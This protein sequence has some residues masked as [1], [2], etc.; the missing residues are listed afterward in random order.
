VSE[1]R[2][3]P[4]PPD[5]NLALTDEEKRA[6]VQLLRRTL[7]FDPYPYA[8]RRLDPLKSI[9]AKLVP[10]APQ[11]EPRAAIA[12]GHGTQPRAREAQTVKEG[13]S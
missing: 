5:E 12:G 9:L 7:D 4:S 11:P 2:I 13:N 6:L 8:P 3:G 1:A 10:P